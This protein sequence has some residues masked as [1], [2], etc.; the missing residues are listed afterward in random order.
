MT[1]SSV[2]DEL[3]PAEGVRSHPT[4]VNADAASIEAASAPP[5]NPADGVVTGPMRRARSG[6]GP[7]CNLSRRRSTIHTAGRATATIATTASTTVSGRW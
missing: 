1:P 3:S 4:P 2:V 7:V 5:N 6:A